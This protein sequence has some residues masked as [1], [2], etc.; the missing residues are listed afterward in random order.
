MPQRGYVGPD[1]FTVTIEP[2]DHAVM[3]TVM[4]NPGQWG[5]I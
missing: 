5:A 2:N 4:V 3:M 1:Q